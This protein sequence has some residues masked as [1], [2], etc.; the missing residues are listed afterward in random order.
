MRYVFAGL[1]GA[2]CGYLAC[3]VAANLEQFQFYT[4]RQWV[5]G[6]TAMSEIIYHPADRWIIPAIVGFFVLSGA[7]WGML[8]VWWFQTGKRRRQG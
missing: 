7:G 3:T 5:T 8:I 6:K 2:C 1:A 4:I